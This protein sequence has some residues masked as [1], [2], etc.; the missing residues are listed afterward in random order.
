MGWEKRAGGRVRGEGSRLRDGARDS[1]GQG[2]VGRAPRRPLGAE[3]ACTPSRSR[4]ASRPAPCGGSPRPEPSQVRDE[5]GPTGNV[6]MRAAL[7][8]P[9]ASGQVVESKSLRRGWHL[10]APPAARDPPAAPSARWRSGRE[11]SRAR[12]SSPPVCHS[13]RER[14]I[15]AGGGR[16][17]GAGSPRP[18]GISSH[19][20]PRSFPLGQDDKG[21]DPPSRGASDF[22]AE[23]ARRGHF[24]NRRVRLGAPPN[25]TP[26]C[27]KAH[28]TDR[29]LR[30]SRRG[31]PVTSES[32]IRPRTGR[33]W[34]GPGT[35]CGSLWRCG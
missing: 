34:S 25:T 23:R 1:V 8:E 13:E 20:P 24:A 27:A 26:W 29:R 33:G 35:R 17:F 19:P 3:R 18:V 31:V 7:V 14:R 9:S 5:G 12:C 2:G 32:A 28:P 15:W 11:S 10:L 4:A 21:L 30:S 16:D 22:V 6:T